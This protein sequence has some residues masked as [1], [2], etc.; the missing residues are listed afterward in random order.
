[1]RKKIKSKKVKVKASIK[2]KNPLIASEE[3]LRRWLR[4][5]VR[6]YVLT[7]RSEP[8]IDDAVIVQMQISKFFKGQFTVN[9]QSLYTDILLMCYKIYKSKRLSDLQKDQLWSK[10]VTNYPFDNLLPRT[11]HSIKLN[12]KRGRF[13]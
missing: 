1:M 8:I 6:K 5:N 11:E 4:L 13:W 12:P 7:H 10:Y 2:R 3:N 9:T